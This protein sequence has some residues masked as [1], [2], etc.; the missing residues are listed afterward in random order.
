PESGP[1]EHAAPPASTADAPARPEAP[2]AVAQAAPREPSPRGL[3]RIRRNMGNT[4]RRNLDYAVNRAGERVEETSRQADARLREAVAQAD[5]RS[6]AR[7]SALDARLDALEQRLELRLERATSQSYVGRD[8]VLFRH[9]SGLQMLLDGRCRTVMPHVLAG[10]YEPDL[11]ALWSE[12]VGPGDAVLEIGANQGFHTLAIALIAGGDGHVWA[13]EPHPRTVRVLHE[14]LVMNGLRDRVT[15]IEAAATDT[16]GRRTFH[17]LSEESAGAYLTGDAARWTDGLAGD[18][19]EVEAI[20]IG[21]FAAK[22]PRAPSLIKV[23]A[24]GEELTILRRLLAELAPSSDRVFVVEIIPGD[25]AGP[26]MRSML[27]LLAE[28][29]LQIYAFQGRA[30]PEPVGED[31]VR[32]IVWED[33]LLTRPG[34]F[35]P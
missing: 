24:E 8:R 13:F 32:A 25:P 17:A 12:L 18:R 26:E 21:A 23:D 29:D 28:H 3:R 34:R 2:V 19:I 15:V 1:A 14:N 16:D 9:P 10:R 4:L 7:S 30:R 20:D 5:A 6:V 22:L 11:M 35:V 27:D 31:Y 33:V